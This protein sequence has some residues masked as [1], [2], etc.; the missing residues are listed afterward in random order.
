MKRLTSRLSPA[1]VIACIALFVSLGGVSYG[2]ATGSIDGR[3]IKD[4]SVSGTDIRNNS[5]RSA[6]IRNGTIVAR[7][8]SSGTRSALRGQTG[9]AGSPGAK[10]DKGDTG[11]TGPT[12]G[13]STSS[14]C[15]PSSANYVNCGSLTLSLPSA[16]R[17]LLTATGSWHAHNANATGNCRLQADGTTVGAVQ[18]YGS[19]AINTFG[20]GSGLTQVTDPLPTGDHTFTFQCNES[21]SGLDIDWNSGT[22]LSAVLLGG[23]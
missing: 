22:H 21:S 1:T 16:G 13:R 17:V 10:G 18:S 15:D 7:D 3:E 4:N 2:V 6:D 9:P 20:I 23:S 8:I 11:D 14:F 5:V 12:L 19:P